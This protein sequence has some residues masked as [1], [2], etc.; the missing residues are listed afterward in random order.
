MKPLPPPTIAGIEAPWCG[1][2]K[3]GRT[4]SAPDFGSA[5]RTEWIAV[6]SSACAGSRSGSN[7][8]NRSA[9]IVLPAP[10]GPDKNR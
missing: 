4:M 2:T 1:A 8:G 6:T 7:E 10:G 3:G 5:P 9:S